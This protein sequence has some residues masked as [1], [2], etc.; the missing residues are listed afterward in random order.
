MQPESFFQSA[1]KIDAF[2]KPVADDDLNFIALPSGCEHTQNR[3]A[4]DPQTLR[5]F[6]LRHLFNE[7]HPG[8]AQPHAPGWA[9][10]IEVF[11]THVIRRSRHPCFPSL[12]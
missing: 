2:S 12:N 11:V 4:P 9:L 7:V 1:F 6:L 3:D 10:I 5:D 8:R